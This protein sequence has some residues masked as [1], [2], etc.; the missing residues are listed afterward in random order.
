MQGTVRSAYTLSKYI[1]GQHSVER[2]ALREAAAGA[3]ADPARRE[4]LPMLRDEPRSADRSVITRTAVSVS[5]SPR[6]DAA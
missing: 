6:P 2:R 3:I 1:L 4:I 5:R